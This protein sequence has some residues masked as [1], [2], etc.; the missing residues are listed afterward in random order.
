MTGVDLHI[1]DGVE[2]SPPVRIRCDDREITAY[3]GETLSAAL[4]A[5]GIRSWPGEDPAGAPARA[6]FCAMGICQQCL[7]WVDGERV[8]ACRTPVRAGLVVRTR[9]EPAPPD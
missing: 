7:L 3:E 8:A 5:A 1:R 9:R 2:R 6:V 4:W